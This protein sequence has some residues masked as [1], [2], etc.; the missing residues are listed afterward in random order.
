MTK[1]NTSATAVQ[2]YVRALLLLIGVTAGA[3]IVVGQQQSRSVD[4]TDQLKL[5]NVETKLVTFKGR[6][7]LRVN[8][9]APAGAGDEVRLVLL[10]K[11]D[12]Q[13]G[14]IEVDLAGEPGPGPASKRSRRLQAFPSLKAGW[15]AASSRWYPCKLHR[16][17]AL[18]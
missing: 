7:A 5:L 17:V 9:A 15:D 14:T 3:F 10:Q 13:D 12:F 16:P 11:T 18:T 2:R 4:L 6:K 1:L 8:D